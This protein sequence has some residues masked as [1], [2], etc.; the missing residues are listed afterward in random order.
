G[1]DRLE[2]QAPR[3]RR[4]PRDRGHEGRRRLLHAGRCPA[5][6]LLVQAVDAAGLG[7]RL[8]EDPRP[9]PSGRGAERPG[10]VLTRGGPAGAAAGPRP[11]PKVRTAAAPPESGDLAQWL[12]T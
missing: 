12:P 4:R 11:P 10:D 2:D 1:R 8:A 7:E 5:P 6:G 9:D 3:H